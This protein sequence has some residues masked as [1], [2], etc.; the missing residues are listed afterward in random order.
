ML[1]P[2]TLCLGTVLSIS[3]SSLPAIATPDTDDAESDVMIVESVALGTNP[4]LPWSETVQINDPF[5]GSFVGV[6]DRHSFSDRVLNTDVHV[7]VQSLWTQ[8]LI[9]VLSIVRDRDCLSQ[10]SGIIPARSCSEFSNARNITQLF[11][12][13]EDDVFQ[14][15]GQGSTFVV[16]DE[17]AMALQN[18]P[19]TIISIRLV[20][21]SGETIDS[22]IGKGTVTAWESVYGMA[23]IADAL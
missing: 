5:E 2:L 1:R 20:S 4:N 17:L 9:R 14:L 22:E 3:L 7:E 8:D 13:I 10:P 11:I 21:E 23:A 15:A 6:F 18:A 19:D 12:K 16:E